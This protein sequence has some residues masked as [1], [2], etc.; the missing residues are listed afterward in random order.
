MKVTNQYIKLPI[1]GYFC[2][3]DLEN[4]RCLGK[5]FED[6]NTTVPGIVSNYDFQVYHHVQELRSWFALMFDETSKQ[7]TDEQFRVIEITKP[8]FVKKFVNTGAIL[9]FELRVDEIDH[10]F[11]ALCSVVPKFLKTEDTEIISLTLRYG[12]TMGSNNTLLKEIGT[13]VLDY[14]QKD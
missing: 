1:S 12:T 2:V 8:V 14:F 3:K 4:K 11:E 13:E 7:F 10:H 9:E 6:E 5:Y